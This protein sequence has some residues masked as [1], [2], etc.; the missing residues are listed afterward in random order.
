MK[1]ATPKPSPI[2]TGNKKATSPSILVL[3]FL[4]YLNDIVYKILVIN[5]YGDR[6]HFLFTVGVLND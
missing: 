3:V 6:E 1:L 5:T 2:A 4:F